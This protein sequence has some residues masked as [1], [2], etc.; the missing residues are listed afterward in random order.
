[1]RCTDP[2]TCAVSPIVLMQS[3]WSLIYCTVPTDYS[4]PLS[5]YVSHTEMLFAYILSLACWHVK[6]SMCEEDGLCHFMSGLHI[7]ISFIGVFEVR[8]ASKKTMFNNISLF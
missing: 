2:P 4:L 5:L 8:K 1:M 3:G 6:T 7:F